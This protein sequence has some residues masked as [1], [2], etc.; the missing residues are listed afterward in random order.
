MLQAV[1]APKEFPS[2][3]EAGDAEDAEL[4]GPVGL[5]AQKSLVLRC[6][7]PL[8]EL[9]SR[10]VQG[11][12]DS[13]NLPG[14]LD[15]AVL[16]DVVPEDSPAEV[17]CQGSDAALARHAVLAASRLPLGKRVGLAKGGPYPSHSRS[18]S[19]HMYFPRTG[20]TLKGESLMP[21]CAV[22]KGPSRKGFQTSGTPAARHASSTRIAPTYE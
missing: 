15:L 2:D 11:V 13:P 22:N 18:R 12:E 10:Q 5:L 17:G 19:R 14:V 16:G 7:R 6:H 3:D 21:S 8:D 20:C 4:S 9:S 1:V